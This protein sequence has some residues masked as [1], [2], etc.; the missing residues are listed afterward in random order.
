MIK[1]SS[2]EQLLKLNELQALYAI[3]LQQTI[4]KWT[5]SLD[6]IL[7][8]SDQS[9][10]TQMDELKDLSYQSHQLAG[11]AGNYGYPE[12]SRLAR[13]F[14]L[15]VNQQRKLSTPV[16]MAIIGELSKLIVSIRHQSTKSPREITLPKTDEPISKPEEITA[17][18]KNIII[19][20]DDEE[21]TK[22]LSIQLSQFN[23]KVHCLNDPNELGDKLLS[24]QPEA[25][26]M[27]IVF[28]NT[29]DLGFD[30]ISRLSSENKLSCPVIFSSARDDYQ[31]RMGAAIAKADG[32]LVKPLN[33]IEAANMLDHLTSKEVAKFKILIIGSYDVTVQRQALLLSESGF[34]ILKLTRP[35]LIL[36]S[37]AEFEA[38]VILIE[39]ELDTGSGF[40][41]AT[42]IHQTAEYLQIPIAF[43]ISKIFDKVKYTSKNYSADDVYDVTVDKHTLVNGLRAKA[44]RARNIQN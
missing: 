13:A 37:L 32:Y 36:E 19:V 23:Y 10:H 3:E 39:V 2:D 38:D 14:E 25:V 22:L 9:Q 17:R 43:Y 5:V 40:D 1:I 28:P 12:I 41:L 27:D 4:D 35:E 24:V 26:I 7:F 42:M 30:V 18:Q 16:P 6:T 44:S 34:E 29:Q 20:D 33:I 31:A 15:K 11:S 8:S 21:L